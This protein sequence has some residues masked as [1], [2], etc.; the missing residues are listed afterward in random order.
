M[1]LADLVRPEE[2]VA[3][4]ISE[5]RELVK[6]KTTLKLARKLIKSGGAYEQV[7]VLLDNSGMEISDVQELEAYRASGITPDRM[8]IIDEEY[9]KLSKKNAEAEGTIDSLTQRNAQLFDQVKALEQKYANLLSTTT[10]VD[11]AAIE[12]LKKRIAERDTRIA[13]LLTVVQDGVISPTEVQEEREEC[14]DGE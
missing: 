12:D 14:E 4:T 2:T 9:Q 7:K 11:T 3:V 1:G 6:A 8:Q 13:E 10:V 5:Y